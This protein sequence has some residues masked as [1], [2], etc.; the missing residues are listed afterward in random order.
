MHKAPLVSLLFGLGYIAT[1]A[2]AWAADDAVELSKM[3]VSASGYKQ[4]A[5]LAPAA[6]TVLE[7]DDIENKPISDLAEVFRDVPGVA[8]VDS[9][10]PGMKRLSVR[11][12]SAR[13]VLIKING[14]P[15]VDHS[16]Y[17]TPLMLDP[18]MIERIEIV[19]GSASVVHG[20]NAIGGVVNVITRTPAD[21]EQIMLANAGY[22]SA[23]NGFKLSAGT[24]GGKENVDYRFQASRTEHGERRIPHGKLEDS[25]SADK[26]FAGEIGARFGQARLAWQGDYFTQTV[27]AWADGSNGVDS[28]GLPER[29]VM[30]N[31]LS[32]THD[33]NDDWL[34]NINA[35]VYYQEGKRILENEVSSRVPVTPPLAPPKF[36]RMTVENISDDS[37]ITTGA[38]LSVEGQWL[39]SNATVVG[40]EYMLDK[41]ITDKTTH[42][43]RTPEAGGSTTFD[44]K[45][46][47][48]SAQQS[49]WSA[50]VQQQIKLIDNVEAHLGVRYYDISSKI[51]RS[52]E[53]TAADEHDGQLVGSASLTWQTTDNSS[54]RL[55]VAQGYSYPSL[56]QQFA[57]TA[58]GSDVHFGN[59]DLKA[60][61]AT[62]Y[63]LGWRVDSRNLTL[64]AVVYQSHAKDFIDRQSMTAAEVAAA[65]YYTATTARQK[66]WQWINVS[67]ADSYGAELAL[68][69]QLA[70]W[71]PYTNVSVQERK[72]SF[73]NGY[74]TRDSGLPSYMART[75]VLWDINSQWNIDAFAR[76]YGNSLKR[77]DDGTVAAFGE[78]HRYVSWHVAAQYQPTSTLNLTMALNNLTNKTYNH[79]DELPAV[80]RSLDVEVNWRF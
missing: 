54:L 60:E 24:L 6:I 39:G 68:A 59:P 15:L 78:T 26:S 75:G 63:E 41:L 44:A 53:R 51:N 62:T 65:G 34:R 22:Y 19:R 1:P 23:T 32:F 12:E 7:R 58:G 20:S 72:L 77:K 70:N 33:F 64:D 76:S 37:L 79:P 46:S 43:K 61:T 35:Q 42:T 45:G 13:R 66:L 21:G 25:S 10:F 31:A 11:G 3:V 80:Q 49:T 16:N 40:M 55:N 14:Q 5:L 17:G 38:L 69:Y 30:R 71:R 28:L 29:S 18:S 50:F 73:A 47:S 2:S 8:I 4:Q 27:N 36:D 57:V 48:Q 9:G 74:S 67:E 56:T 52:T